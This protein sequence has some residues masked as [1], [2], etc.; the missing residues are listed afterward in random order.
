VKRLEG[1]EAEDARLRRAVSDPTLDKRIL[2]EAA[3]GNFP[4]PARRRACVE[5][6]VHTMGVPERRACAALGQHRSTRREA[7]RGGGRGAAGR[8]A[9]TTRTG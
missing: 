3:R 1:L 2:A 7:P 4:G 5:H 9:A 6:I 8:G